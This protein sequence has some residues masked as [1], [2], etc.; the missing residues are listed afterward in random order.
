MGYKKLKNPKI[1]DQ[2]CI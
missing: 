2:N 1:G